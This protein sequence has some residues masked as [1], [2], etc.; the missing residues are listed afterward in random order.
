MAAACAVAALSGLSGIGGFAMPRYT[1]RGPADWVKVG[2][3]YVRPGETLSL[4]EAEAERMVRAG[5]RFEGLDTA[6]GPV[7]LAPAE[8]IRQQ[9]LP[10]DDRGQAIPVEGVQELGA[11]NTPTGGERSAQSATTTRAASAKAKEGE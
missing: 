10:R 11:G 8:P 7:A 2:D 3:G 1:Y 4:E 5:H 6:E 9:L